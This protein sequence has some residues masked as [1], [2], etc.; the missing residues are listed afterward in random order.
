M[1]GLN[2]SRSQAPAEVDNIPDDL[3]RDMQAWVRAWPSVDKAIADFKKAIQ[4]FQAKNRDLNQKAGR[5]AN[6]RSLSPDQKKAVQDLVARTSATHD[7]LD[8]LL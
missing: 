5:K 7:A 3:A 8:R 4:D 1:A 6:A 2:L